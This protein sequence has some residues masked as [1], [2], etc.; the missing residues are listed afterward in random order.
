MTPH[1]TFPERLPVQ[2]VLDGELVALDEA[3]KPD[4]PLICECVLQRQA[5]VPL[6]YM[7]F[8]VLSIEGADAT[9]L[10]YS[11][12]RAILEELNLNEPQWRTPQVFDDGPRYGMP[13]ASTSSKASSRR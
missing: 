5:H 11:K 8:D 4:S 1:V 7:F 2:A 3:G 10:P 9:R 13:S 6:T 12:R